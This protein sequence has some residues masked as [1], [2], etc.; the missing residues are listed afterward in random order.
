MDASP[1]LS[2]ELGGELPDAAQVDAVLRDLDDIVSLKE[3]H[4]RCTPAVL[5][6]TQPLRLWYRLA[7]LFV[8]Q[9]AVYHEEGDVVRA[10]IYYLK[11]AVLVIDIM[12]KHSE[13]RLLKHAAM[14][15]RESSNASLAL[16]L[17]EVLK[18]SVEEFFIK[19]VSR[20]VADLEQ[21]LAIPLEQS[22]AGSDFNECDQSTVDDNLSS[23]PPDLSEYYDHVRELDDKLASIDAGLKPAPTETNRDETV[24]ATSK[25][26]ESVML[27]A[28]PPLPV[29]S[30]RSSLYS[31]SLQ[32]K[33]NEASTPS[34]NSPTSSKPSNQFR[35]VAHPRQLP[36]TPTTDGHG[37]GTITDA[38][39]QATAEVLKATGPNLGDA[40]LQSTTLVQ[41]QSTGSLKSCDDMQSAR[42]SIASR[43]SNFGSQEG[44]FTA[45]NSTETL[46]DGV[47]YIPGVISEKT[48]KPSQPVV[49]ERLEQQETARSSSAAKG[50]ASSSKFDMLVNF[51]K[52]GSN[53]KSLQ[54]KK[55]DSKGDVKRSKVDKASNQGNYKDLGDR[56]V[57]QM[58]MQREQRFNDAER[59]FERDLGVA[60]S[61]RGAPAPIRDPTQ[62]NARTNASHMRLQFVP[63]RVVYPGH[64]AYGR[65]SGTNNSVPPNYP[66]YAAYPHFGR[67]PSTTGTPSVP[68]TYGDQVLQLSNSRPFMPPGAAVAGNSPNGFAHGRTLARRASLLRKGMPPSEGPSKQGLPAPTAFQHVSLLENGEP[69]RTIHVPTCLVPSFL[70][71]A[72][73]N[74]SKGIETCGILCGVLMENDLWVSCLVIPKQ[75]GTSDTCSTTNE[76]ELF[77]Y[78]DQEDLLT[79]GWIHTHPTQTCFMSSVDLHTH[80]S[81]QLLLPESIAIVCAPKFNPS[82]GVFRLTN[83]P[84]VQII[85]KCRNPNLFHP[86]G[87]DDSIY[88]NV[89]N[90]P[91]SHVDFYEIPKNLEN[92][93]LN[94]VDM[95]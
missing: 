51:F 9:A 59:A 61:G 35:V 56:I 85:S 79:L 66:Y 22:N 65:V 30:Y 72:K 42:P 63:P 3:L 49:S 39:I 37:K 69:L 46:S 40:R 48:S 31:L 1:L 4:K 55:A 20:E 2:N 73:K 21:K 71:I 32:R 29:L 5:P 94:V 64:P 52:S 82:V 92:L 12:P 77:E 19:R 6:E 36:Q 57:Q 86:H 83:P 38:A 47:A 60:N 78:L 8:K 24:Q 27:L 45:S 34:S 16:D 50:Q 44:L 80:C 13:A 90:L 67:L 88:V 54:A 26:L 70:K 95:R 53:T 58:M 43:A 87:A 18:Q 68:S 89:L 23:Y 11:Y 75:S 81:Y 28:G 76:D 41:A 7:R 33:K 10:Y 74:T 25:R 62:L 14:F 91:S 84:G 17:L 93:S 15:E